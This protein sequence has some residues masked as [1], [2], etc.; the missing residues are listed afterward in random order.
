VANR[1]TGGYPVSKIFI[2]YRHDDDAFAAAHLHW[3][4]ASHFGG[5]NVFLDKSSLK[6]GDRFDPVIAEA[7]ASCKVLIALI[8]RNWLT[9]T[10][11][12]QL[13]PE[14][15]FVLW[16]ISTVLKRT[17]S[18]TGSPVAVIPVLV[19]GAQLPNVEDLPDDLIGLVGNIKHELR[20]LKWKE[21]VAALVGTIEER[22]EPDYKYSL[23]GG[24]TA[25]LVTALIVGVYYYIAN[26]NNH[27]INE[28]DVEWTRII[29][30]CLFGVLAGAIISWCINKGVA[31]FSK[32]LTYA[33]YSKIIGGI[34]G[35]TAGGLVACVIAGISFARLSGRGA[36]PGHIILAV[37]ISTICI[38]LGMIWPDMKSGWW[39]KFITTVIL[40]SVTF[41]AVSAAEEFLYNQ[42]QGLKTKLE[43]GTPWSSGVL[44]L[45]A[46]CGIMAGLQAGMALFLYDRRRK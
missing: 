7:L 23:L 30:G 31:L 20:A 12:R 15:D 25:G 4:L 13:I 29:S 37:A 6:P 5:Q 17:D 45:G 27:L 39:E 32:L 46:I 40:V 10:E 44:I 19:G 14:K 36:E 11:E 35:G 3:E 34:V 22:I 41:T 33:P 28:P 16:E 18:Q 24:A 2:S 43:Q 21:D 9:I 42:V 26:R 1:I 38:V 8:G